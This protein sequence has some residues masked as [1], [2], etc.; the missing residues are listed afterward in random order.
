[1]LADRLKRL[2]EAGIIESSAYRDARCA[3]LTR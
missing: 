3:T 2:E 1:M